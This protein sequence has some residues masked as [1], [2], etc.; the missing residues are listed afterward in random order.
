[1]KP[2]RQL[3][4]AFVFTLAL[5]MPA[6]AGQIDTTIAPPPPARTVGQIDIPPAGQIDT[7]VSAET[8]ADSLTTVALNL[9][10]RVL[11]LF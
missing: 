3:C 1:M 7:G 10:Q 6:F 2:L 8:T 11:T 5:A 9:L 4:A